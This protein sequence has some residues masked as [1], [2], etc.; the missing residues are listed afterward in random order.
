M[1]NQGS[2]ETHWLKNVWQ[3]KFFY[4]ETIQSSQELRKLLNVVSHL[5]D[6]CK[7]FL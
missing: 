3:W 4:A 6:S 1:L 2:V 5:K 7:E